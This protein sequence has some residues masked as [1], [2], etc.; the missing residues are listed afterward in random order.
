MGMDA[1]ITTGSGEPPQ[2]LRGRLHVT[3]LGGRC[4]P[5]AIAAIAGRIA[6]SGANID[7][8]GQAGQ[9]PR[10]LH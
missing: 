4:E 7:R 2:R 8:I 1:E 10:Y 9:P 3:V 5:S 6:A